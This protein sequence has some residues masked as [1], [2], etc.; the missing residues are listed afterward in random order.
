MYIQTIKLTK[1]KTEE[2]FGCDLPKKSYTINN[3]NHFTH[4]YKK[5][6]IKILI[7]IKH[8]MIHKP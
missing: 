7:N 5:S 1:E 8:I 4:I 2:V 3:T 6:L